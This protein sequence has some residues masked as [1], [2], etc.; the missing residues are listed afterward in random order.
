M[1]WMETMQ[2]AINYMELHSM[3]DINYEDVARHVFMASY[4]FHRAFSFM[5]GMTANAYLVKSFS[6]E[7]INDDE[8]HE[9]PDF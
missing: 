9:I 2:Q 5:S 7:I 3:D 8:N 4:E 6:I 1:E